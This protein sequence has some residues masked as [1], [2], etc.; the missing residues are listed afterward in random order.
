MWKQAAKRQE[1]SLKYFLQVFFAILDNKIVY[2][3]I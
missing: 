1:D 2:I 3:N